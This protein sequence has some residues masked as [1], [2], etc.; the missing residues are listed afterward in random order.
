MRHYQKSIPKPL[1]HLKQLLQHLPV[2]GSREGREALT[3]S[4]HM[5][6]KYVQLVLMSQ[7]KKLP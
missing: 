7:G 1:L 3:I 5:M 4:L 2:L 6:Q